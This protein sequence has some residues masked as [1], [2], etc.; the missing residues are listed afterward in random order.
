MR[1]TTFDPAEPRTELSA[2]DRR[3]PGRRQERGRSLA[4][5]T[6]LVAG[7]PP[8]GGRWPVE[9]PVPD[10]RPEGSGQRP[11]TGTITTTM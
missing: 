1:F 11:D 4:V 5:R 3:A 6:T 10:V 9:G 2:A 7:L 8:P